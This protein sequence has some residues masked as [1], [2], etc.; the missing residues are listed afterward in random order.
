MLSGPEAL[1]VFKSLKS[2]CIPF[3]S[4]LMS[5]ALWVLLGQQYPPWYRK[6]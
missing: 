6:N 1:W 4:T 3:V 2:F 5:G